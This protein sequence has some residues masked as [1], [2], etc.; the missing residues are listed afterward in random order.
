[1][2]DSVEIASSKVPNVY[3]QIFERHGT[4][5]ATG[6]M[7]G[8]SMKSDVNPMIEAVVWGIYVPHGLH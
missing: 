2:F 1:L 7:I 5:P 8:N 6:M 4:G 3:A